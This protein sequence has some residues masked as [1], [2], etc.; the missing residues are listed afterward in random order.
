M[1]QWP[2]LGSRTKQVLRVKLFLLHW[3]RYLLSV[4]FFLPL[5][6]YMVCRDNHWLHTRGVAVGNHRLFN[7]VWV[8]QVQNP[9]E[10]RKN[11]EEHF[12]KCRVS[13]DINLLMALYHSLYL[14]DL[15]ASFSYW[16][17]CASKKFIYSTPWNITHICEQHAAT[18]ICI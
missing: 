15:S 9:E 18:S 8:V 17:V 2:F 5:W 10:W 7:T 4:H 16:K 13:F 3:K 11:L 6:N 1:L 12:R 14:L